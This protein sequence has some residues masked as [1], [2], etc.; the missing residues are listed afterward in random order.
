M[1]EVGSVPDRVCVQVQQVEAIAEHQPLDEELARLKEG[2]GHLVAR[3][4][5]RG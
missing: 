2:E 3:G 4:V 1:G 5:A